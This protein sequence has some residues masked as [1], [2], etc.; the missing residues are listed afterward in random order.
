MTT[1]GE[2]NS[3][4]YQIVNVDA[5]GAPT[6]IKPQYI[7]GGNSTNANYA[8]YS[9]TAFSVNVGNV[10]GIGNIA[11][12]N[13]SGNGLQTLLGNGTW[14]TAGGQIANYAN[15][16]GNVTISSQPNITSVGTLVSL[17][18]TGN[19]TSGNVSGG[20][21][22]SANYISGDGS[23]LSNL[24]IA[25]VVGLGNIATINLTGSSTQVLY[26]NGVFSTLT[27]PSGSGI[28]NGTSNI[29]IPTA[30]GNINSSVGGT[31]NVFVVTATGAN[32]AG[33]LN[34]TGNL[35]SA[36]ANLG[37][38]ASANYFAGNGVSITGLTLTNSLSDVLITTPGTGQYLGYNG[39]NWVNS[40]ISGTVS[41]GQGVGF[42]FTGPTITATSANNV[43]EIDTLSSSPNTAAQFYA[44]ATINATTQPIIATLSTSLGRTVIDAGN[45]D[46]SVWANSN[47]TGGTVN[48]QPAVY[49]VNAGAGTITITGTG[50]TRTATASTDAPFAN[51]VGSANVQLCSWLETPK[52]L[53][54]ISAKSSSTVVTITTPSAYVNDT[55]AAYS[56][57]D[58]FFTLTAATVT[59]TTLSEYVFNTTQSSKAIS[60]TTQLGI[61]VLG[62]TS[63]SKLL[64]VS[65]NGTTQSSHIATPLVT[66]HDSLA[67]LQGGQTDEY[68]HLTN[69]EYTGTGTGVFARQTNAQLTTPNIDSATGTSLVLSGNITSGNATLGNLTTSN[70]FSGNG[71]LLSS[72][73]GANVTGQVANALVAGTVYTAAQPNITSTGTLTGLNVSSSINATSF[74]SNVATGTAP[75]T[76][77]STTQVGNLTVA[78]ANVANTANAVAGG[79]VSG[80]V[81]NALVAGTVYTAAQPNI[82]STGTLTGLNVS[83]SINAT[84]FTS[85]IATGTAPL[86]V[87]STTLV[88]NLYVSRA[89]VS[90][91]DIVTTAT[92]G[93]YYPAMFNA[94]TGNVQNYAN[95][96]LAFNAATGNL[97]ATLLTGTLTTAAQ[98]N[99]TS[100]GALTGLTVSNATGVVNFITTA[101]VSLG[102]V[103]NLKI[104]G[105]SASQY[106]QTDGTGN[107]SWQT[108]ATGSSSNISNGTSNVNIATSGG[109]VTTTVGGTANVLVITTTGANISGTGNFTG[110]V[111]VGNISS[112]GLGNIANVIFTKYSEKV[113][114]GGSTGAVTLTP[115]AAAGTIYNYTLTGNITLNALG[116][117]VAGT[118]MTI[119]LTQ[120]ATGGRT[121]TSTMKFLGG[122]KT[123]ST[124]ANAIDIMSVFYD[125]TTYYASLGKGFA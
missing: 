22:V 60:T 43:I 55:A 74:S 102:S 67:G 105:G 99:I 59:S 32:I 110:N 89:N 118:G 49:T 33:T 69:S 124:S 48:I 112:T 27:L 122:T 23:L 94:V 64:R 97:S 4:F 44:T 125:G 104:T 17:S 95:S 9:G 31:P 19:I 72:I 21:L 117:A 51:S 85:N 38:L 109:N 115:D 82:T 35:T 98:P 62:T 103:A 46:F 79:N 65:V 78:F 87:V 58:N 81:A 30:G 7:E 93:T 76:V 107:L 12:I 83:S 70:Y 6:T 15:Y 34:S 45:W 63:N 8:N 24:N 116:N 56:V 86:S 40:T 91:Y 57:Y 52:G 10:V 25:N 71:S 39:V 36:N 68:Y 106:L 61:L 123:L 111:V 47:T 77:I 66:L 119:I 120:D 26:G 54:Q 28:S 121:L 108:V 73:T 88:P 113:I 11:T 114:A 41:A 50:T 1:R 90:D 96:A 18:V 29:N 5:N 13:L 53:Y 80:Q 42:W 84:S 92:T 75:F 100:H 14:G 101:N 2:I 16:A 3:N 20:N 37:N